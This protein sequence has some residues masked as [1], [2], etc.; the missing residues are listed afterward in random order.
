[1]LRRFS[2]QISILAALVIAAS[3]FA[4]FAHAQSYT[5]QAIRADRVELLA[6]A[7][8][9][10][11]AHFGCELRKFNLT[12]GLFCYG[13]AAIRQAYGIDKLIAAGLD[14]TGQ[15]IVIIDAYGSPTVEQDLA[16]FDGIFGLPAP[17][18]F[19]QIHMPGSTPFDFTSNN[20]LG[21][22]EEVS[23]DV[24]WSHAMAPG[25]NI[26]VVAAAS[27]QNADMLAAQNFAI[28][29][30]LGKI[31][32]ESFGESELALLQDGRDGQAD[33]DANE[34]SYKRARENHMSVFVSAGDNGVA[35]VNLNG[36][37]QAGPVAQY[38]ASSPNVTTV[39]GTNLF[40][41]TS[42][43]A[44]PNGSYIGEAVWNDGFGAGGGGISQA[45]KLP[46]FQ[47][48]LPQSTLAQLAR[49][50]GYPDVA[51]N[52]GVVGGVIVHLGFLPGLPAAGGNFI[53]GGTSAGAP[54][55]AGLASL[56]NQAAGKPLGALNKRLYKLGRNGA[57]STFMHDITLGDNGFAGVTGFPAIANWDLATGWGTPNAGLVQQLINDDQ[58]DDNGTDD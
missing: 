24:Q 52:A 12:Q 31:M 46:N 54:Q 4:S 19:Q 35:G 30:H 40:F 49:H 56:A 53:F 18:S 38:P 33:L 51:Y 10:A 27:N 47:Q 3:M 48:H 34:I 36:A 23:L 44:N 9:D 39:G 16:A 22:A 32:S 25:A 45:F 5:P 42:T 41:G 55:W 6:D 8:P 1:M 50:R 57:L 37:L 58:D 20:Q 14:G 26:I 28:D 29:A 21:W 2:P 17:P 15:T 43:N 7:T 11:V 13:P